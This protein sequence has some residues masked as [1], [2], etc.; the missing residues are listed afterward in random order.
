MNIFRRPDYRSD[1]TQFIDQ[2]KTE[3][4]ALESEQRKGRELLWDKS[5][6]RAALKSY[7]EA[8]VPQRPYVYQTNHKQD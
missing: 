6:D 7:K 8:S 1:A 5:L 3:K 2:L 4:P